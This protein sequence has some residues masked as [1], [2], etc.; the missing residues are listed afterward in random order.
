VPD[1]APRQ[2][3]VQRAEV[4]LSDEHRL[5]EQPGDL[6]HVGGADARVIAVHAEHVEGAHPFERPRR[7]DRVIADAEIQMMRIDRAAGIRQ[8]LEEPFT[9]DRAE[10]REVLLRRLRERR[11]PTAAA[12]LGVRGSS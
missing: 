2:A 5:I 8:R 4:P 10:C 3:R 11:A 12:A 1:A 7:R 6:L 9:H